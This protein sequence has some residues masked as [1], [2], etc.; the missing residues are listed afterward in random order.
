MQRLSVA[1]LGQGRPGHS[2]QA[3]CL[4]TIQALRDHRRNP[5]PVRS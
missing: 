4:T 5:L 1:I 2:L 3:S